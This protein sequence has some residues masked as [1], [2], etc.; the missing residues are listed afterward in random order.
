MHQDEMNNSAIDSRIDQVQLRQAGFQFM[1][2]QHFR[3][4]TPLK[5]VTQAMVQNNMTA[6]EGD[7]AGPLPNIQIPLNIRQIL[8]DENNRFAMHFLARSP[9]YRTL[10]NKKVRRYPVPDARVP[11]LQSMKM[12]ITS[13]Y[14]E[15]KCAISKIRSAE[16]G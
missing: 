6:H 1:M 7:E 14:L 8:N 12:T 4:V 5:W 13:G 11:F 3:Q 10:D 15:K 2:E 16:Q 9:F